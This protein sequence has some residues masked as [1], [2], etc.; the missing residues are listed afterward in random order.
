MVELPARNSLINWYRLNRER[1]R[2]L[3]DLLVEDHAYYHQPIALRHPIVF[4][5]GHLPGFSFNTLIKGA[6][7]GASIDPAL[8]SLFARG[9][10][11][12]TADAAPGDATRNRQRWPSRQTVRQF[13]DEADRQVIAAISAADLD[14]PGHPMLDRSEA[15][16]T[17]L[18]HEALHQETLL[19]IWH[20]LPFEAKR[21]PPGYQPLITGDVP[22]Q[23]WI[24]VPAAPAIRNGGA[25]TIGNG[26]PRAAS[27]SRSSGRVRAPIASGEACSS[28]FRCP[29]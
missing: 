25:R 27:A 5:E 10:D 14:R 20:R 17:I 7:G 24:E 26:S 29:S 11:P 13:A 9:I 8:E 6:L 21:R 15:V 16:F 1:S 19:Y 22:N 12:D 28:G 23:A 2:S 4:Y 3:F 18:E